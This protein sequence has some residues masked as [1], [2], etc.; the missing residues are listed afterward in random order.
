MGEE[1]VGRIRIDSQRYYHELRILEVL[2]KIPLNLN[3][4]KLIRKRSEQF[5][6]HT[7][8]SPY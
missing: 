2:G 1:E 7:I 3:Y 5:Y 4:E 6:I 8:D